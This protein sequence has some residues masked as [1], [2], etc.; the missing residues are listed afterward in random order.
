MSDTKFLRIGQF[1]IPVVIDET[2][3][4]NDFQLVPPLTQDDIDRWV[5]EN[6]EKAKKMLADAEKAVKAQMNQLTSSSS[7]VKGE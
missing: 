4:D 6:P 7:S 5:K 1:M 2:L 3:P